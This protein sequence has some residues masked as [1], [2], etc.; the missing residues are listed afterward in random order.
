M[1]YSPGM[2]YVFTAHP[3]GHLNR[4]QRNDSHGGW[5]ETNIL[6]GF[7]FSVIFMFS[8]SY[9][10]LFSVHQWQA[11]YFQYFC[12]SIAFPEWMKNKSDCLHVSSPGGFCLSICLPTLLSLHACILGLESWVLRISCCVILL[13][14]RWTE[15]L[16]IFPYKMLQRW[17]VEQWLV[18]SA[19]SWWSCLLCIECARRMKAHMLWM[20]RN[21]LQLSIHTQKIQI[22]NSLPEEGRKNEAS[23]EIE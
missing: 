10:L 17:L 1:Y 16:L 6:S 21:D 7:H 20:N 15:W 13:C 23:L 5:T 14:I 3:G 9:L 11:C 19:P 12:C 2:K 8:L 18:F 4:N 22:V